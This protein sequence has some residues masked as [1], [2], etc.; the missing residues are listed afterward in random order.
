MKLK[1]ILGLVFA[2]VTVHTILCVRSTEIAAVIAGPYVTMTF[3]EAKNYAATKGPKELENDDPSIDPVTLFV[4]WAHTQ[5]KRDYDELTVKPIEND[6]TMSA[7]AVFFLI[8]CVL[9]FKLLTWLRRY[10]LTNI[11]QYLSNN[12]LKRWAEA[13]LVATERALSKKISD[14]RLKNAEDEFQ[15]AKNLHENGLITDVEFSAKKIA[16]EA[17]IREKNM[18]GL[19]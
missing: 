1:S 17:K 4:N 7:H 3:D 13:K 11:L 8:Y 9:A 6:V 14:R 2:A 19:D 10:F 15:T 12:E 5:H 18:L 16:I